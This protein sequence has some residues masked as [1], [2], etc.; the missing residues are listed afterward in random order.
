MPRTP[1]ER[2]GGEGLPIQIKAKFETLLDVQRICSGTVNPDGSL[3][4]EGWRAL[5]QAVGIELTVLASILEVTPSFISQVIS[6]RKR[7]QR[8]E[9]VLA[10]LFHLDSARVWGRK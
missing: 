5:L 4:P 7:S 3:K 10:Q 6:R 2:E 1:S 9:D 8:V